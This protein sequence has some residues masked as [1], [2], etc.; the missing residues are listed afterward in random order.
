[1]FFKKKPLTQTSTN[2]TL[3]HDRIPKHVA[4]IMDGNGRWAK[5]QGLPRVAGHQ[6]GMEVVKD[7]TKA[8]SD[9]GVQALTLYAFSTENWKRPANEVGFLMKL[10]GR[11]FDTFVPELN[12]NNVKVQVMG[13]ID[14]LPAD[15]QRAVNDAIA[16]TAQNTGMVLN[17][18]LNYGGRAEIITGVQQLAQKVVAGELEASEIDETQITNSLMTAPLGELADPDLLIRT[19]GEQRLSNFMLWQLAYAEFVFIEQ[20]WPAVTPAV[21]EQAL[22]TYQMRDRRFGGIKENNSDVK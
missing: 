11:F 7:I 20:H 4:I 13:Y 9:L 12:E 17:F 10:P 16:Q 21:F 19:S 8:A 18:A 15:T 1:M 2:L 5:Q 6:R 3:D 14:Q 22:I